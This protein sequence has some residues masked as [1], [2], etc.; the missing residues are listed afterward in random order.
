MK[1]CAI[2]IL[3]VLSLSSLCAA[4]TQFEPAR[5]VSV[6]KK[7][8]ERVLYYLVNTPVTQ[9]DPYYEISMK[10]GDT[11][12]L[13]EFTPRHAADDLPDGWKDD[14]LVQIEVTDKHHA[15]AKLADGIEV[16]LLIVRRRAGTVASTAPKPATVKN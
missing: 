7:F 10:L 6:E 11:I 5:I 2:A 4:E 12:L 16:H 14:A 9:D 13:T 3:W 8:H 15:L 1:R